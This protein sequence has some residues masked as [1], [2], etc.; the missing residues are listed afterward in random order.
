MKNRTVPRGSI[1]YELGAW[2]CV[3]SQKVNEHT[4]NYL[5]KE[6]F[7]GGKSSPCLINCT[8]SQSDIAKNGHPSSNGSILR[9]LTDIQ[10]YSVL[11]DKQF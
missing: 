9:M 2:C 8:I 5:S 7:C 3:I 1:R 6:D 11:L 10:V 4:L